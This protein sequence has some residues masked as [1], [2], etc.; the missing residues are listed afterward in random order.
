MNTHTDKPGFIYKAFKSY[1]RFFHDK[2]Y[3]RSVYVLNKENI[4]Q[5]GK[6]LII[7]SN[8]QNTLNDALAVLFSLDDRKPCF[9]TRGDVFN[10]RPFVSRFLYAIGLLPSYRL[11]HEGEDSLCRNKDTFRISSSELLKGRTIVMF[12]EAGH[13]DKHWLG[14]FSYGYLRLAFEAAQ[15]GNFE[16]D[17]C[18]LPSCNHYSSYF[19]IRNEVMVRYGKPISLMPYYELYKS[20]PRTAQREINRLVREQISSMMLDVRDVE[21]YDE[22]DLI[23]NTYP[24]DQSGQYVPLPERLSQDQNLVFT[25]ERRREEN[26]AQ[27]D[28][29]Y[30]SAAILKGH[31]SRYGISDRHIFNIPGI[32]GLICTSVALLVSFPLWLFSCW[33][34]LP[35]YWF[36]KW[37]SSKTEDR[38]WDGAFLYASAMLLT[39]P[40]CAI[41]TLVAVGIKISWIKAIV[42]VMLFP[43]LISFCWNWYRRLKDVVSGFSRRMNRKTIDPMVT[44]LAKELDNS[45]KNTDK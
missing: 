23:R 6:P 30:Q 41:V 22:I 27:I 7:V 31:I 1:L 36:A 12:P 32:T 2:V 43:A 24:T 18:I 34:S 9:I 21:H 4:P 38:M 13:Q 3:Y 16:K 19:G 20:K 15:K 37:L 8:H 33:P 26:P 35:I 29:I 11:S 17:I 44:Y 39:L 25:L 14:T 45:I 40:L 5:E 10:I 42:Y 28:N